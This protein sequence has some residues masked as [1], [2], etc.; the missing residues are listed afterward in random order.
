MF[1]VLKSF[2][3]QANVLPFLPSSRK[4]SQFQ[5]TNLTPN[6]KPW[7]CKAAQQQTLW[8]CKPP[9]QNLQQEAGC[10]FC[11]VQLTTLTSKAEICTC[12]CEYVCTADLLLTLDK[13]HLLMVP[14][15]H[16][17]TDR[18]Q[19]HKP[20]WQNGHEKAK[21][22]TQRQEKSKEQSHKHTTTLKKQQKRR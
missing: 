22:G 8:G 21:K 19:Q 12:V 4:N 5:T 14:V 18:Q 3:H 10:M 9:T 13:T 7:D 17:Q 2:P 20:R 16:R 15:P 11:T 6:S 1:F